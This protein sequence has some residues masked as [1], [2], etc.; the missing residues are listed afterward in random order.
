MSHETPFVDP[1]NNAS[2]TPFESGQSAS[3]DAEAERPVPTEDQPH[4]GPGGLIR[5]ELHLA[6]EQLSHFFRA[7]VATQHAIMTL[8]ETA[9]YLRISATK[10]RALAE[11]GTIPSFLVE[12]HWRFAKQSVDEWAGLQRPAKENSDAA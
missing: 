10:L 12:G 1:H 9:S 4:T 2:R 6:P 5:I 8:R 11:E 7:V 3:A